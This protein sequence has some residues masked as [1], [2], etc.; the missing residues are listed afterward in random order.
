M[1]NEDEI[2]IDLGELFHV[3][4]NKL[5]IILCVTVLCAL[6]G[7]LGTKLLITP[8]YRA[9]AKLIVNNRQDTSTTTVNSSDITASENLVDTYSVI[10]TSES[11]LEEVI[12]KLNLS[13]GYEALAGRV[14]VA[15]VNGT[16]IMQVSIE[17][18]DPAYAV[19]IIDAITEVAPTII[20]EK[21]KAGSCEIISE[22]RATDDPVSP[23]AK[24]NGV[25][26]G[27]LGLLVCAAIFVVIHLLDTTCK[28]ED[29]L[30]ELLGLP[31]L[32]V[33]PNIESEGA[34]KR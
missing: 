29:E 11:V 21:V 7:F 18:P 27:V 8:Q 17:D 32:S 19:A 31:V 13:I 12:Q 10:I 5:P 6:F 1:N 34:A 20:V 33:I 14:N 15:A 16:Q 28:S 23:N 2:S 22:A 3:L 24:R 30:K 26:A 4:L 9:S 25:L